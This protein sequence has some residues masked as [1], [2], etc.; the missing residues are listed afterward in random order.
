VNLSSSCSSCTTFSRLQ[1]DLNTIMQDF[2][3]FCGRSLLYGQCIYMRSSTRVSKGREE[4]FGMD[5]VA[6]DLM[7]AVERR[8]MKE[9]KAILDGGVGPINE[10][11]CNNPDLKTPIHY[12]VMNKD[13]CLVKYLV[14]AGLDVK[15][16]NSSTMWN[17]ALRNH[18]STEIFEI[19]FKSVASSLNE[20]NGV[21]SE[22][23]NR[24][25]LDLLQLDCHLEDRLIS[26]VAVYGSVAMMKLVLSLGIPMNPGDCNGTSVVH[27]MIKMWN[28][29]QHVY[30]D[31]HGDINIEKIRLMINAGL[32]FEQGGYPNSVLEEAIMMRSPLS[33]ELVRLLLSSSHKWDLDR[34]RAGP[35]A[36]TGTVTP[37]ILALRIKPMDY[38]TKNQRSIIAQLL[39]AG[40]DCMKFTDGVS[41]LFFAVRFLLNEQ[42]H[43]VSGSNIVE[44]MLEFMT[45]AQVKASTTSDKDSLVMQTLL[46]GLT[47]SYRLR[48][49]TL[50]KLL[51]KG[52]DP[53]ALDGPLKRI[54]IFEFM[55]RALGTDSFGEE[56]ERTMQVLLQSGL[57]V[58]QSNDYGNSVVDLV[59]SRK[60]DWSL[61]TETYRILQRVVADTHDWRV[62]SFGMA[63]HDKVLQESTMR[64]LSADVIYTMVRQNF[65]HKLSDLEVENNT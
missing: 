13:V 52:A 22:S 29:L 40:A 53:D 49:N 10:Y 4:A 3:Y 47:K 61:S 60:A 19:L 11:F 1:N 62:R 58:F 14:E 64:G 32:Q 65:N 26:N 57:D 46:P 45:D 39:E 41:V 33:S 35:V 34:E 7:V 44:M 6:K 23:V 15:V 38:H 9:V 55:L 21:I 30:V 50:E 8:R 48:S 37:L 16:T 5:C 28:Q 24:E 63:V 54:P 27:Q 59:E 12:A 42:R 17:C 36:G 51:A 43:H 18:V 31:Y 20:Q 56:E 25:V 2:E